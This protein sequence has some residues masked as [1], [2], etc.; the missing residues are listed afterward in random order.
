MTREAMH[1]TKNHR[2]PFNEAERLV[3]RLI[4]GKLV[5]F[6]G[7][8]LSVDSEQNTAPRLVSRLLEKLNNL[9]KKLSDSGNDQDKLVAQKICH[10]FRSTFAVEITQENDASS[11]FVGSKLDDLGKKLSRDYYLVNDWFV[12]AF[13]HVIDHLKS[14]LSE[15]PAET[16][17]L[18]QYCLECINSKDAGKALFLDTMGFSRED[19]MASLSCNPSSRSVQRETERR[20][21]NPLLPRHQVLAKLALE[22]WTPML[23]TTNYDTLLE[24]AYQ[25]VGMSLQDAGELD[26]HPSE[27]LGHTF[28]RFDRIAAANDFF[29]RGKGYQ[30]AL[31]VRMHGC[32]DSYRAIRGVRQGAPLSEKIASN[33]CLAG[34]TGL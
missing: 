4:A 10:S 32:V 21:T 5:F 14:N 25:S 12:N 28:R 7:A 6:I 2:F 11:C 26:H 22:G 20:V 34:T 16:I 13:S 27:V 17:G 1:E 3:E 29:D 15:C 31:V 8:G 23:I 18:E 30:T 9:L 33:A 24:N 19:T